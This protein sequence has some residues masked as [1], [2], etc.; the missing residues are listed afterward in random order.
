MLVLLIERS[1]SDEAERRLLLPLRSKD[2]SL[3]PGDEMQESGLRKNEESGGVA[4]DSA[5]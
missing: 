5:P 3:N 2:V 4:T 1:K